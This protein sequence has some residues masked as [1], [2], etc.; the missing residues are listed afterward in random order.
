MDEWQTDFA[1][2]QAHLPW[3]LAKL[4]WLRLVFLPSWWRLA[5]NGAWAFL[6]VILVGYGLCNSPTYVRRYITGHEYGH[7]QWTHET[8]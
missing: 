7:I 3:W 4:L 1:V 5:S 2:A 6:N 8:A